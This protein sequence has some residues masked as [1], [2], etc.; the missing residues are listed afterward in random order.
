MSKRNLARSSW[1]GHGWRPRTIGTIALEFNFGVQVDDLDGK[2]R[3]AIKMDIGK[4]EE[5]TR[6][7]ISY[8]ETKHLICVVTN[9]WLPW[10]G[11]RSQSSWLIQNPSFLREKKR[12][13]RKQ[14]SYMRK[15]FRNH[16][17][18]QETT[19]AIRK[20]KRSSRWFRLHA[21]KSSSETKP[22]EMDTSNPREKTEIKQS[23]E[24]QR[25][26]F[27]CSIEEEENRGFAISGL[28][29]RDALF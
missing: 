19:N 20:S 15:L 16:I 1:H 12:S 18:V 28:G 24:A 25:S 5:N 23:T 4:K 21:S 9:R 8:H 29:S 22:E 11:F 10:N 13:E 3:I 26:S 27:S 6:N 7:S 14:T 2:E 17:S